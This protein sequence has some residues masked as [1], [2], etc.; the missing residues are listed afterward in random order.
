MQGRT[1]RT[2]VSA[3]L[4]VGPDSESEQWVAA[5]AAQAQA[6]YLVLAK[7]RIGDRD[8]R[9]S[10]P[11]ADRWQGRTPVLVDDIV[12]TA[13]TMIETVARFR[14]TGFAEP[15]AVGIHALF[16]GSAFDDLVNAG[17][18]RV[19]TCNTVPHPSNAIDVTA[20][21]VAAVRSVQSGNA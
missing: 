19:V 3:P 5:V 14:A 15:V 8:V 7:T 9:V 17:V 13:R 16:V 11:N 4:V 10:M 12:S 2:H 6:P 21:L 1:S 18:S 20:A